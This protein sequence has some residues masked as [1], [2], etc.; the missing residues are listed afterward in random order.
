[1]SVK[2]KELSIIMSADEIDD[3][4]TELEEYPEESEEFFGDDDKLD[5]F[6]T[7]E[8]DDLDDLDDF[9]NFEE[10]DYFEEE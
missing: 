5:D 2:I 9:G 3:D 8:N 1:M 6:E 10:E 7:D 4:E